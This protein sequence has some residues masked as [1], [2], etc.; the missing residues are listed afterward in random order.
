MHNNAL[1]GLA[2]EDLCK[3]VVKQTFAQNKLCLDKAFEAIFC[4]LEASSE[5]SEAVVNVLASHFGDKKWKVALAA[6]SCLR[7]GFT[8]FGA[9]KGLPFAPVIAALPKLFAQKQGMV[10][11]KEPRSSW[12]IFSWMKTTSIFALDQYKKSLRESIEEACQKK[13]SQGTCALPIHAKTMK[14]K[15]K[16]EAAAAIKKKETSSSGASDIA[17]STSG[18][19]LPAVLG[20]DDE[21]WSSAQRP[22]FF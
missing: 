6:A 14:D 10:L 12:E 20:G 8:K 7:E 11:R 4:L 5:A 15:S 3:L 2:V 17:S 16:Y 18:G 13:G 1:E 9:G 22:G 19:A 21:L